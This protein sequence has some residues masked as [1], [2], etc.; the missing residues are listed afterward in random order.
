LGGVVECGFLDGLAGADITMVELI[1][2]NHWPFPEERRMTVPHDAHG[3]HAT[4]AAPFTPAEWEEFH[5]SDVAAGTIF[6]AL[7]TSIFV[8]G[9]ILYSG[10]LYFVMAS[11]ATGA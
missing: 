4:T 3:D 2:L 9:L 8:I 11:P 1:A 10:V 6:V 5:K 7:I